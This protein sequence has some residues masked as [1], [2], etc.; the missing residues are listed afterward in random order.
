M[1]KQKHSHTNNGDSA[2]QSLVNV[3]DLVGDQFKVNQWLDASISGVNSLNTQI[4]AQ[5]F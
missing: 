3:T 4:K 5:W 1:K 2:L